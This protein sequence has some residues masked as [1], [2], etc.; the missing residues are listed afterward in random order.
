MH[1]WYR[2][3]A[4]GNRDG[5]RIGVLAVRLHQS[6]RAGTPGPWPVRAGRSVRNLWRAH[7]FAKRSPHNKALRIAHTTR[8]PETP[9]D[10]PT[11]V[12]CGGV[13]V[14]ANDPRPRL[15]PTESSA[16]NTIETVFC[17]RRNHISASALN[18]TS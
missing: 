12:G 8:V 5:A 10:L 13:L 6:R 9:P 16:R 7:E 15:A 3:T 14:L 2:C 17:L 4:P 1:S 11:T 18:D